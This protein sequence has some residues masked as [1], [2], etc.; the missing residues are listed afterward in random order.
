ML[1]DIEWDESEM[2]VEAV[3]LSKGSSM[4]IKT[5]VGTCRTGRCHNQDDKLDRK[6]CI[7]EDDLREILGSHIGV[8]EDL[9]LLGCGAMSSGEKFL[10]FRRIL[11]P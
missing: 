11:I 5:S 8:G 4:M 9:S 2:K 6:Y 3:C 10:K 7:T 1:L